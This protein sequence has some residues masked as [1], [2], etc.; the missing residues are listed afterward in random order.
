MLSSHEG[1][2]SLTPK[3]PFQNEMNKHEKKMHV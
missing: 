1:K 3:I 2:R